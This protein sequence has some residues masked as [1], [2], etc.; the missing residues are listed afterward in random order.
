M[1][2]KIKPPGNESLD[3]RRRFL[4]LCGTAAALLPVTAIVG[5]SDDA[6]A[7]PATS[8]RAAEANSEMEQAPQ[9]EMPEPVA[10]VEPEPVPEPEAVVEE[11][12]EVAS[13]SSAGE[14][15]P[16]S[17]D[18]PTAQALGYKH[19]AANVDTQQYAQYQPGQICANCTLYQGSSGDEWGG[20]AL[21]PGNT[22][23]A[24]GWCSGY[25]PK[26]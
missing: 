1:E 19:D 17:L 18:N 3:Q 5:C 6:P 23:N 16:V 20:C 25:T 22:V 26:A 10:E 14:M 11:S 4:R 15:Q 21:F 2:K 24:N 13:E 8:S 12:V 7:P 9:P